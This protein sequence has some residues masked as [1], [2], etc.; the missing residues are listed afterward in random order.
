MNCKSLNC[1]KLKPLS[2]VLTRLSLA[3]IF[4]WHGIP[5]A[6]NPSVAVTKFVGVGFPG[7]LGPVIGWLEVIGGVFLLVGLWTRKTSLVL[8]I[9]ILV[10]LLFVHL[11]KGVTAGLE[12][13]LLIVVG[14]IVLM[15]FGPGKWALDLRKKS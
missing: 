6:F 9:I 15:G 13:D 7:M 10:A 14:S 12:R 1:E 5:K 2:L 3:F 11:P 8:G 4:L